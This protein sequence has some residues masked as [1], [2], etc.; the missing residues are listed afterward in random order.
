MT[1]P[2]APPLAARLAWWSPAE[3][4]TACFGEIL[5]QSLADVAWIGLTG[6]LGSGKTVF[7]R[8]V[9]RGL[10]YAGKVRSPS[11]LLEHRYAGRV[12][13]RHLDLYRLEAPDRDLRASWEDEPERGAG[14]V[15]LVEWAERVPDPPEEAI[16]VRFEPGPRDGRWILLEWTLGRSPLRHLRLEGLWPEGPA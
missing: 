15:V 4:A 2:A 14:G 1:G 3:A 7:A 8:G 13:I 11:F 9:A 10:G 5:G 12:S 16:W 6:P